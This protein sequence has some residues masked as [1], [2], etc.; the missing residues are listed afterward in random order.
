MNIFKRGLVGFLLVLMAFMSM[1]HSVF[2][3]IS[4]EVNFE[5]ELT[6]KGQRLLDGIYGKGMFI[7]LVNVDLTDPRYEVRYTRPSQAAVAAQPKSGGDKIQ[8]LP[9][10][11]VIRN[12]GPENMKQ[13]PFDSVTSYGRPNIRQ[14]AVTLVANQEFPKN[15]VSKVQSLIQNFLGLKDNRDKV[16]VAF[17]KF[18]AAESEAA[19]PSKVAQNLPGPM[20]SVMPASVGKWFSFQNIFYAVMMILAFLFVGVYSLFQFQQ[21]RVMLQVSKAN[22]KGQDSGGGGTQNISLNPMF[23]MPKADRGGMGGELKLSQAPQIKKYFDFITDDNVD[24]L[25]YILKKEKIGVENLAVLV[26][27]LPAHLAAKVL[28]EL[29]LK[30]QAMIA[31]NMM[32]PKMFNKAAVEK[33]ETQ[34]KNAI[35]C[36]IGGQGVFDNVF[37]SVSPDLKRQLL[38]LLSKSNPEGYKKF[39]NQVV[40]FE[41]LR[42]LEDDE[43]KIVISEVN[44]DILWMA[45]VGVEPEIVQKYEQNLSQGNR[46]ILH[47]FMDLRG[48][49]ISKHDAGV[50]QETV[51][52]TALRLEVEGKIDLKNKLKA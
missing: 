22:K 45:L 5:R 3:V 17:Q 26:P 15:Q 4:D 48:K 33:F 27:C 39:R 42:F 9:G 41:D 24:R 23:D 46:D 8:I 35:E 1:T 51:L 43:L 52:K 36:L 31:V 28:G 11:P 50:A 47:Q 30:S 6:E 32:D 7:V 25:I 14:I 10:Y 40:V 19:S 44:R 13:M 16:T 21:Q 2:A 20:T 18:Y 34:L 37:E 12:L 38:S 29:D 49:T